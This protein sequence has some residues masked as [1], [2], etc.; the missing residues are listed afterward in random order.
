[1]YSKVTLWSLHLMF[2]SPRNSMTAFARTQCACGDRLIWL[3]TLKHTYTLTST[4]LYYYP[5]LKKSRFFRQIFTEVPDV[6]FH[7]K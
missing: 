1:M 6:K 2:I 5:M 4:A 3:A 7:G